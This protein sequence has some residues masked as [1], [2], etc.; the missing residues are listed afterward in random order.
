MNEKK[1]FECNL[2]K[3]RFRIVNKSDLEIFNSRIE[4]HTK[5]HSLVKKYA[6]NNIKGIPKYEV[7][8]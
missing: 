5:F 2:C 8:G 7:V 3:M 6:R 1:T 4:Q